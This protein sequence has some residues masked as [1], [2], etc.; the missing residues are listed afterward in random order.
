MI[1]LI[2]LIRPQSDNPTTLVS[3]NQLNVNNIAGVRLADL[4]ALFNFLGFANRAKPK[5]SNARQYT[6]A[7]G[8]Q[9]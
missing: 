1:G 9:A 8:L 6:S 5:K 7:G 2:G 4:T 3:P